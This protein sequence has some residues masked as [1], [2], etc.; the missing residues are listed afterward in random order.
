MYAGMEKALGKEAAQAAA[1]SVRL[2]PKT[3]AGDLVQRDLGEPVKLGP[4]GARCPITTPRCRKASS[5]FIRIHA[6]RWSSSSPAMT[7]AVT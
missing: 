4:G 7:T 5:A 3:K 2:A 1:D 6:W